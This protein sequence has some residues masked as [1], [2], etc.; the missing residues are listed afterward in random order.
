MEQVHSEEGMCGEVLGYSASSGTLEHVVHKNETHSEGPREICVAYLRTAG[1][2]RRSPTPGF[3]LLLRSACDRRDLTGIMGM[4]MPLGA[5]PSAVLLDCDGTVFDTESLYLEAWRS[6]LSDPRC[7]TVDHIR[8][9]RE[10]EV[11]LALRAHLR[12]PTSAADEVLRNKRNCYLSLRDKGIPLVPGA[13][14]LL[15]SLARHGVL[16]AVVSSTAREE[17]CYMFRQA[18]LDG[19]VTIYVGFEDAK[20]KPAPDPWLL[21]MRRLGVEAERCVAV[22]DSETGVLSARS[23]GLRVFW[24]GG[25]SGEIVAPGISVVDSLKAVR[26]SLLGHEETE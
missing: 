19:F 26:I 18:R 11:L 3:L 4:M 1:N 15:T 17:L 6:Q 14:A 9:R 5:L 13:R 2:A 8:G 22:E 16:I 10:E 24:L 12:D 23:A 20:P 21:A 25:Q 7:I